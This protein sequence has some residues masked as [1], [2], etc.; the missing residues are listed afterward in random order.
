MVEYLHTCGNDATFTYHPL[1]VLVW[2]KRLQLLLQF[3]KRKT[4]S[5]RATTTRTLLQIGYPERKSP[6]VSGHAEVW[7]DQPLLKTCNR[8]S[9]EVLSE[10][11]RSYID[12]R[13]DRAPRRKGQ[14]YNVS[15]SQ[16]NRQKAKD[17]FRSGSGSRRRFALQ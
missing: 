1:Q 6:T 14:R 11:I 7:E 15:A 2:T 17:C 8:S 3:Y 12:H 4:N 10:N 16:V 13:I 5:E 9:E